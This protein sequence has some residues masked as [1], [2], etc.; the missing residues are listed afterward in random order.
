MPPEIEITLRRSIALNHP[1]WSW[2]QITAAVRQSKA[3]HRPYAVLVA[4]L[5][6][7]NEWIAPDLSA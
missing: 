5:V 3:G 1:R 4:D 2:D 6:A 7:A